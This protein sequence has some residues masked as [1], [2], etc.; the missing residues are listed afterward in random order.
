MARRMES[1]R[2]NLFCPEQERTLTQSLARRQE[3]SAR[4]ETVAQK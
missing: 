3:G 1:V 4:L 2:E